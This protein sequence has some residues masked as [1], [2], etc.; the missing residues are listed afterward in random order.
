VGSAVQQV[1]GQF[2]ALHGLNRRRRA[3]VVT[4][5]AALLLDPST[6][7]GQQARLQ[8]PSSTLLSPEMIDWALEASLKPLSAES[9][10]ELADRAAPDSPRQ[11]VAVP[12]LGAVVLAGNVFTAC[13]PTIAYALTVGIPLVCKASS[14][15]QVFPQL[16]ASAIDAVD[17]V[18][19][20]ALK[21][22]SFPGGSV[23]LEQKLFDQAELVVAYGGDDTMLALRSRLKATSRLVEHGHG[24]SFAYL[25]VDATSSIERAAETA[26]RLALDVAAYDQRGCFSPHVAWLREADGAVDRLTF[27]DLLHEALSRLDRN[28]PR[29]PLPAEIAAA[30]MQWRGVAAVEGDL[31][32]GAG[33]AVA[34][35]DANHLHIGPDWRNLLVLPCNGPA[36]L[37]PHLEPFGSHLKLLGVECDD[38]ERAELLGVLSPRLCPRLCPVGEMQQPPLDAYSEGAPPFE[39]FVRWLT[40]EL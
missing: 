36:D 17:P 23:D 12:R 20:R 19:G 6:S 39:G 32:E 21:V 30:Q 8:L 4:E 9:L 1:A 25:G 10:V 26:E 27:L 18:V 14:A 28:L 5:A 38:A 34:S 16:F 3:Q 2:N 33:H 37:L 22:F 29:G 13:I 15:E 40:I 7:F 24:I 35:N 31:R 11:R